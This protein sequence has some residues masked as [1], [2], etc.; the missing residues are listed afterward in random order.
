MHRSNLA[1][2]F[3]NTN[4]CTYKAYNKSGQTIEQRIAFDFSTMRSLVRIMQTGSI[5]LFLIRLTTLPIAST[6]HRWRVGPL[7]TAENVKRSGL[8]FCRY[9]PDI[10]WDNLSKTTKKK[11]VTDSK[12]VSRSTF[13][14]RTSRIRNQRP[15]S[16]RGFHGLSQSIQVNS[17]VLHQPDQESLLPSPFQFIIHQSSYHSTI[18]KQRYNVN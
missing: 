12:L 8:P 17:G 16:L 7:R 4:L 13:E 6:I 3:R 11:S 2:A 9:R 18:N 14:I 5:R 10:V 1:F 15:G